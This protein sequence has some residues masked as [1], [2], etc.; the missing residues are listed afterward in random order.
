MEA[1]P[2]CALP[3]GRASDAR[4]DVTI[5]RLVFVIEG[6]CYREL[7]VGWVAPVMSPATFVKSS[8]N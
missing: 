3:D 7:V 6:V 5:L 8:P 4:P 2:G 1:R